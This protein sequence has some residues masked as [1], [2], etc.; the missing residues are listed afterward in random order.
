[1]NA[2]TKKR[3]SWWDGYDKSSTTNSNSDQHFNLDETAN[4][5][6]EVV[7]DL[8]DEAQSN[9]EGYGLEQ[10]TYTMV[11]LRTPIGKNT[12]VHKTRCLP[13]LS[14]TWQIGMFVF[15]TQ[16]VLGILVVMSLLKYEYG[17][18]FLNVPVRVAPVVRVGQFFI[19]F[20]PLMSQNDVSSSIWTMFQ[21]RYRPGEDRMKSAP[22]IKSPR[23]ANLTMKKISKTDLPVV[24]AR[25]SLMYGHMSRSEMRMSEGQKVFTSVS[26]KSAFSSKSFRSFLKRS[27]S[28]KGQKCR[29][30]SG[31]SG[32]K[33]PYPAVHSDQNSSFNRS[34][35]NRS[36][37]I[38]QEDDTLSCISI[39]RYLGS[40]SMSGAQTPVK[41]RSSNQ[42]M[43]PISPTRAGASASRSLVGTPTVLGRSISDQ[44]RSKTSLHSSSVLRRIKSLQPPITQLN[45]LSQLSTSLHSLNSLD[46]TQYASHLLGTLSSH[47]SHLLHTPTATKSLSS[48]LQ[49]PNR[50]S[51]SH[52]SQS[53]ASSVASGIS[54]AST[55]TALSNLSYKDPCAKPSKTMMRSNLDV[56][57]DGDGDIWVEKIVVS[58]RSGKKRTFF[59]SVAT[60]RRVRDE[61]PTGASKVLYKDDLQEL[62]R[63]EAEEEAMRLNT[64]TTYGTM[65][66]C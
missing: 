66:S 59:V 15:T 16:M 14:R 46:G 26:P 41:S 42:P 55:Y 35:G 2:K 36:I 58:K 47:S 64:P 62:R 52:G 29:S 25:K 57:G 39:E 19:I 13:R 40:A 23:P 12:S 24:V 44:S 60:G 37:E 7:D 10:D 34:I 38:L 32:N 49:S 3:L 20:L 5:K 6:I 17:S 43:T 51:S 28:K 1:M 33:V 54:F 56:P 8:P 27:R 30:K 18:A 21:L 31:R 53:D 22:V 50:N 65:D 9:E 4:H 45:H 61:P 63:I 48:Y 11:M